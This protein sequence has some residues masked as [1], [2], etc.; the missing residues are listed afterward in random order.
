MKSF[1]LIYYG[2]TGSS[3]LIGTL[4]SAPAAFIPGF[5]PLEKWAW[6]VSDAERLEWMR[7]VFGGP[8]ERSGPSYEAWV[9]RLGENPHFGAPRRPDFSVVG[10][11]MHA[12]T[13]DDRQAMLRLLRDAGSRVIVLERHNRIKH[14]LSLYRYHEESKSQFDRQGV[15]PPSRVDLDVFQRWVKESVALHRQSEVFWSDAKGVL[16]SDALAR[17]FYEDFIDEPGKVKTMERLAPFVGIE[18]FSYEASPFKKA[19]ADSLE[20]AVVNFSELS[21]RYA[22]TEFAEFLAG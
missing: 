12:H 9:D 7:L 15:R 16:G 1:L 13:I 4:G 20:E 21:A 6:E 5:E 2:N 10:F 22:G 18:G 3:W 19:T 17:V 14:A 8:Q 11:K